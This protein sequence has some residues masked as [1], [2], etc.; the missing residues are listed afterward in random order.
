M[1]RRSLSYLLMRPFNQYEWRVPRKTDF[2]QRCHLQ[3][4]CMHDRCSAHLAGWAGGPGIG[5]GGVEDQGWSAGVLD[6]GHSQR[7]STWCK[8]FDVRSHVALQCTWS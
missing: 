2:L 4:A 8:C 6:K 3:G 5:D 1:L 7:G